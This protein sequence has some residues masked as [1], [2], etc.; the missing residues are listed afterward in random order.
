MTVLFADLVGSTARA[1]ALDPE[2]VRAILAPFYAR[3]R[4][5]LERFG[6]TVEKFIGDAVMALFGA[7][8]AHEDDPERAVRAALAIRDWVAEEGDLQVRIAVNTGEALISL[9]ARP[10]EGEGMA[11]GDV[12]NTTA[13]LQSAAPVDGILVGEST[14]RATERVIEYRDAEQVQAKGKTEPLSVWE[15]VQARSRFGVDVEERG[16]T[17]LVG[18]ERELDVVLAALR[19][20]NE[21]RAPQLVSV[22]GVPGMGKSRLVAELFASIEAGSELVFWRQG[23][24]LPYGEGVTY[25]ALGEMT[26]AQ[27]GILES[28]DASTVEEKLRRAVRDL[29]EAPDEADRVERRL[30]PVVGLAGDEL[31]GDRRGESFDAWRRFFEALADQRPLVLVFEDLHWADD[32]LLD[33][34][35][36]LIDWADDVPLLV[37]ATARPELLDRRPGWGGGKANATTI[38]LSPL[39]EEDTA[40]LVHMLLDRSVLPADVRARVLERAGGNPLF[41]GEFVRML[42]G[43]N[44][45]EFSLP[46]SVQGVIAARLDGLDGEDKA[47]LQDAAV[48]GK[49]FWSGALEAISGSDQAPIQQR[50]H[51]VAR[52][53]FVRRERRS[54]VGGETQYAFEHVLVRDVAYAQI[55]RAVRSQKHV[56]AAQWIESLGRPDDHAEM[57]AHHYLAALEY[58]T[59]AGRGTA[60]IGE[61]ARLALRE[62]GDRATSLNAFAAACRY[63]STAL[64]L[65]PVGDADRPLLLFRYGRALRVAEDAGEDVLIEASDSLSRAG[66]REAAAEAEVLL[67]ELAWFRG[68]RERNSGHLVRAAE[69]VLD[70]PP[71][72]SKT[73][74]LCSLARYAALAG[75]SERA[76][77]LAREALELAERLELPELQAYALNYLGT[78]RWSTGDAGG[79]ADLER[80]VELAVGCGSG[81]AMRAY[82]NLASAMLDLGDYGRASE[83]EQ[84]GRRIA[85]RFGDAG[86]LRWFDAW[87]FPLGYWQQRDW[88]ECLQL[89]NAFIADM[90]TGAPHYLEAS[91]RAVRARIWLAR[92][93][94]DA[95]LV[96]SAR[97]LEISRGVGDPQ[98]L[99]PELALHAFAQSEEGRYD[100]SSVLVDEVLGLWREARY[101]PTWWIVDVAF[102]TAVLGRGDEFLAL[103]GE[104]SPQTRWLEAAVAY[105]SGD[106]ARA[107]EIFAA[108]GVPP[109]EAYAH[110]RAAE[111]LV[112]DGNRTEADQQLA[113]ALEFYRTVRATRYIREAEALLARTA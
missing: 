100:E 59:A 91:I 83:L 74:V 98:N 28:D 21:S 46:E 65:W 52:K 4:S 66:D 90:E 26:K 12:V 104:A 27:A 95:G 75:D 73:F 3:L 40:R 50:L 57:V 113:P 76:I 19:R 101:R 22:V 41:A 54:A 64:D 9:G 87:E 47:L 67:A 17:P 35:D 70:A 110:L 2:D 99:V 77:L 10:S 32:G 53:E 60:A 48:V 43:R 25:W 20:A 38:S 86:M 103:A 45:G 8:V 39:S 18:R 49:V 62:A 16:R 97:A 36:Y 82:N 5:E 96:E 84:A 111:A 92:G 93:D 58:A 61:Q 7:P 79:I 106:P 88:D 11:S 44:A 31:G 33:F 15:V 13:R 80:S 109:W 112:A 56:L 63:Y 42:A 78:A 30:R 34:V 37:V 69:L 89:A 1:E 68:D 29:I 14:Y 6:G 55:P 23:R 51:A 85:E 71:S 105:V 107:A 81:E 72:R 102:A 94:V 108:I 24:S